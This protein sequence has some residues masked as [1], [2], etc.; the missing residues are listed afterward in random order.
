MPAPLKF[1]PTL[2]KNTLMDDLADPTLFPEDGAREAALGSVATLPSLASA[3]DAWSKQITAEQ[4]EDLPTK[5]HALALTQSGTLSRGHGGLPMTYRV[6]GEVIRRYCAPP[7]N[8]ARCLH[9]LAIAR[10]YNTD[11]GPTYRYPRASAYN[12]YLAQGRERLVSDTTVHLRTRMLGPVGAKKKTVVGAVTPTHTREA[13]DDARFIDA[14]RAHFG[15]SLQGMRASYYR[16]IEVSEL[17]SIVPYL[18]VEL[19]PGEWWSGYLTVRNSEVGAASWSVAVGL[20][21]EMDEQTQET[22]KRLGFEGATLT[23]E[24]HDYMGVHMGKNAAK[25]IAA[26]MASAEEKLG[27]VVKSASALACALSVRDAAWVRERLATAVKRVGVGEELAEDLVAGIA[28]AEPKAVRFSAAEVVTLLG[29][30]M[31][32]VPTRAQAYPLERLAGRALLHGVDQ[33]LEKLPAYS[34]TNASEE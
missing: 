20:V 16:G 19:A 6:F 7:A 18:R 29:Q 9:R 26:A 15:G 32:R 23:V 10:R 24:A 13:T 8:V 31:T 27:E 33:T 30:V 5:F 17:R 21:K 4:P 3:L 34:D 2:P 11:Q 22:A 14:I 25:R 12:E 28:L 1:N